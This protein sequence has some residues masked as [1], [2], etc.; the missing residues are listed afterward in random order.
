MRTYIRIPGN[1][2]TELAELMEIL[3]GLCEQI[4][5]GMEGISFYPKGG[6]LLSVIKLLSKHQVQYEI[7]VDG[8]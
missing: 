6:N 7:K 5:T 2:S 1:Y 8:Q 4:E 3:S